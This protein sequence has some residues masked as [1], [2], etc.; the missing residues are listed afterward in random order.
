MVENYLIFCLS[1]GIMVLF[2]IHARAF[3]LYRLHLKKHKILPKHQIN[4]AISAVVF[5]ITTSALA[6]FLCVPFVIKPKA[7]SWGYAR[8][9]ILT[10]DI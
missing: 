7:V 9:L 6:P 5:F 3:A 8:A 4:E 10:S 1:F 2:T